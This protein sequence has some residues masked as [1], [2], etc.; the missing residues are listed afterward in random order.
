MRRSLIGTFLRRYHPLVAGRRVGEDQ[1]DPLP[2]QIPSCRITATGSS[3]TTRRAGP[4]LC[5]PGS[6]KRITQKEPCVSFPCE[7]L[8]SRSSVEPFLPDAPD[9]PVELPQA[10]VVRGSTVVPIVAAKFRVE[11]GLLLAHIVMSMDSAPFGDAVEG[12]SEALLH[13]PD[14]DRELPSPAARADM[15]EAEEVEGVGLR[16]RPNGSGQGFT[17]KRHEPCLLRMEG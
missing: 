9:A 17:P 3:G 1:P 15:L 8:P 4:R 11:G 14:M 10:A 2:S 12:A 7:R 13:R 16:P 5:D 6:Q